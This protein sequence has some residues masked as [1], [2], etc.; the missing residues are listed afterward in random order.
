LITLEATQQLQVDLASS[1]HWNEIDLPPS[2][3]QNQLDPVLLTATNFEPSVQAA[4][5][6]FQGDGFH[7]LLQAS[8]CLQQVMR[9]MSLEGSVDEKIRSL[10]SLDE[11]VQSFLKG[12]MQEYRMPGH[13]CGANAVGIR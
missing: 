8:M 10:D 1:P 7:R 6:A 5:K 13:H 3:A 4:M 12:V 2:H 9:Y 11:K